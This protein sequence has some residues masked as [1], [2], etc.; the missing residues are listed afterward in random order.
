MFAR[1]GIMV[2]IEERRIRIFEH[3]RNVRT[4]AA[5]KFEQIA[6]G[7]HPYAQPAEGLPTV[8]GVKSDQVRAFWEKAYGAASTT[9]VVV[10]DVTPDAC[11]R[12]LDRALGDWRGAPAVAAV[13]PVDPRR[14]Q[15]IW[16]RSDSPQ[17]AITIGRPWTNEPSQRAAADLANVVLGG[18]PS[19]R[20]ERRLRDELR[21]TTSASSGFWRGVAAGTWSVATAVRADATGPAIRAILD[22]ISE[23]A[24]T[25]PS[26]AELARAKAILIRDLSQSFDTSS[27][28]AHAVERLV[29]LGRSIDDLASYA[30]RVLAATPDDVRA[31][32]APMASELSIV[33]VGDDPQ[34]DQ[35]LQ[36]LGLV[37]DEP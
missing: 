14:P 32:F 17:A 10:G 27:S 30:D 3:G 24:R 18:S 5:Q 33:V 36:G 35:Q 34:T 12:V 7:G 16:L 6:F 9:V 15:R 11:A 25:G 13:P 37:P 22:E 23:F 29:V 28:A 21:I 20:L 26:D 8:I 1:S 19:S 31:A 2:A 4:I